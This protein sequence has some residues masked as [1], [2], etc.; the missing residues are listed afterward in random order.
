MSDRE[1]YYTW[2]SLLSVSNSELLEER[3]LSDD[4]CR[5]FIPE[6]IPLDEFSRALANTVYRIAC[7]SYRDTKSSKPV[8]EDEL[9]RMGWACAGVVAFTRSI[10]TG[11]I[12]Y[13]QPI[14]E[15]LI[16]DLQPLI[17]STYVAGACGAESPIQKR[18]DRLNAAI[19]RSG[20]N[21]RAQQRIRILESHATNLWD[22]R[23]S[24]NGNARA[25][26][27]EIKDR[28]NEEVRA[29]GFRELSEGQIRKVLPTFK[30]WKSRV[31]TARR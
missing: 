5:T 9:T 22:R 1:S 31:A 12:H 19:A 27:L 29:L 25:T 23:P 15:K 3:D 17:L 24:R 2:E 4:N 28:V 7:T 6:E 18:L 8:T 20:K 13:P 26:M 14:R 11:A 10:L 30:A 21:A 16:Y